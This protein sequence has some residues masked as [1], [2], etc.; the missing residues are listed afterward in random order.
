MNSDLPFQVAGRFAAWMA[1][2]DLHLRSDLASLQRDFEIA[3]ECECSCP[4][5]PVLTVGSEQYDLGTG[6]ACFFGDALRQQFSGVWCGELKTKWP[7]NY[8]FTRI[9]FGDYY[10]SP[11]S[12]VG[13]RLS[14]GRES[15]GTVGD[16]LRAVI[17]SMKDGVDKKQRRIDAIIRS[18]GSVVDFNVF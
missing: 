16:C 9:R 1:E 11:F 5:D 12:W 18:G 17:P 7:L 13:Y 2:R 3:L 4:D 8:Y 6:A 14:N 10:F 15:E